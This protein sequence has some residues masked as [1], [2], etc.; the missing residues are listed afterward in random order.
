ME[1]DGKL[2]IT[3]LGKIAT[4][5]GG[6][7][8]SAI[9][10]MK[11]LSESE[12]FRGAHFLIH[13]CSNVEPSEKIEGFYRDK[14]CLSSN[15]EFINAHDNTVCTEGQSFSYIPGSI[16]TERYILGNAE[17]N[18]FGYITHCLNDVIKK[19]SGRIV[20]LFM[21]T[22]F[23]PEYRIGL[24]DK[25]LKRIFLV[26]SEHLSNSGDNHHWKCN[27]YK[28]RAYFQPIKD[29]DTV[30]VFFTKAQLMAVQK[31]EGTKSNYRYIPHAY[32]LGVPCIYGS[33][34]ENKIVYVGK[35]ENNVKQIQ[36]LI[37]AYVK[38]EVAA[39]LEIYGAGPD[40]PRMKDYV[41]GIGF[42]D[43]IIF[44]G[45]VSDSRVA[46]SKAKLSVSLTRF[47]GFGLSILESLASGCPVIASDV[48]YGPQELIAN[49]VNG[50]LV[51][52]NVE[53]VSKKIREFFDQNLFAQ[54]SSNA[55]SMAKNYSSANFVSR[56]TELLNALETDDSDF[57][58]AGEPP[59]LQASLGWRSLKF[60]ASSSH[61]WR[62]SLRMYSEDLLEFSEIPLHEV[63]GSVPV[64]K[65]KGK[66]LSVTFL[67]D[68]QFYEK[69]ISLSKQS[70]TTGLLRAAPP[71]FISKTIPN[72]NNSLKNFKF[73]E[74]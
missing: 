64:A 51:N 66:L 43:K 58:E 14:Y 54:F 49:N 41:K 24:C 27:P 37:D 46:F 30:S 70:A 2:F 17:F 71:K 74:L 40:L 34:R 5:N 32:D 15:V 38:S 20:Y 56:W 39:I 25:R 29:P 13:Y 19:F 22:P 16:E 65:L 48:M 9:Y 7:T 36:L 1:S 35:I 18:Y 12:A 4:F 33:E 72:E 55:I 60:K 69:E 44:K 53:E 61:Q 63:G 73:L 3:S 28:A 59:S 42:S 62:I 57:T 10:R 23:T 11:A 31:R 8:N 45:F 68:K 26:H 47:E 52:N 6:L 67:K 21:D 50:F